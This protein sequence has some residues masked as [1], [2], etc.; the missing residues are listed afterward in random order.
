MSKMIAKEK[1]ANQ[2]TLPA[3]KGTRN[4]NCSDIEIEK[5]SLIN[6]M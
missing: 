5:K 3:R 2:T 1:I 4:E 6:G